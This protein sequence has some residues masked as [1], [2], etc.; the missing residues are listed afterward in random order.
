MSQII[1]EFD[2]N[3]QLL[4]TSP[5]YGERS[6]RKASRSQIETMTSPSPWVHVSKRSAQPARYAAA[7]TATSAPTSC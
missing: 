3:E 6:I 2:N 5:T 4:A 1:H 7:G